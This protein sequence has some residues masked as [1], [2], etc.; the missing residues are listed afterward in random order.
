MQSVQTPIKASVPAVLSQG[1]SPAAAW[2]VLGSACRWGSNPSTSYYRN[3]VCR[4]QPFTN[5]VSKIRDIPIGVNSNPTPLLYFLNKPRGKSLCRNEIKFFGISKDEIRG[6]G[7]HGFGQ[8]EARPSRCNQAHR[9]LPSGLLHR[10]NRQ[11]RK[12]LRQ[13]AG[14][15]IRTPDFQLGKTQSLC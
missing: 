1:R 12:G 4:R 8:V 3:G 7:I 13:R 6:G 9:N 14:E 2:V 5:D 11:P 10:F 15:G